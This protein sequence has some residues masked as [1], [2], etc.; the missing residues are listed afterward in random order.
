MS[1]M[2]LF[3]NKRIILYRDRIILKKTFLKKASKTIY[4]R[5]IKRI[6]YA[7]LS[8]KNCLICSRAEPPGFFHI[9]WKGK[10]IF[11][12]SISVRVKYDKAKEIISK[13]KFK[14]DFL[15]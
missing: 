2:I 9:Y 4:M 13:I 1:E 14:V 10:F 6:F 3:E 5:D 7:K 15:E 11:D 12:K 8:L